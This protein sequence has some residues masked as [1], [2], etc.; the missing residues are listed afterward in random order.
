VRIHLIL[1]AALTLGC[2]PVRSPEREP[3]PSQYC[4]STVNME[5]PDGSWT[6]YNGCHGV[7]IDATYEFDPDDPP[8]I[9]SFKLQ[10]TGADEP[11]FECWLVVT[12]RGICGPGF[13]DVGPSVSTMIELA[14][15]DCD[16]VPDEYEGRYNSNDGQIRVDAVN[17]GSE[18][19]D[20]TNEPLF[21]EFKGSLEASTP[22]G[23]ELIVNFEV[24]A[25][26]R[27]ED[28]EQTECMPAD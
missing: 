15:Y 27:G 16:Y 4:D 28:S 5:F 3:G 26:L 17:A 9:R 21:T 8:D 24:G 10:L 14:T 7:M 1:L 23:I 18:V 25:F 12:S 11:G 6:E 2:T 19:G 20:F 22:E 13:Y